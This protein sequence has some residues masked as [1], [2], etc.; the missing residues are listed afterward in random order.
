MTFI[1]RLLV[2]SPTYLGRWRFGISKCPKANPFTLP[3][4]AQMSRVSPKQCC[5]SKSFAKKTRIHIP[6]CSFSVSLMSVVSIFHTKGNWQT[7]VSEGNPSARSP[8]LTASN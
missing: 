4:Q 2:L 1:A 6:G 8:E 3:A 5:A 7:L